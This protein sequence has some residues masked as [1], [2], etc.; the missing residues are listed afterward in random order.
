MKQGRTQR[1]ESGAALLEATLTMLT[2][3]L[4]LFGI[5]E[6]GR[7]INIQHTLTNA[8]RE[9]ARFA[10][11]PL[12]SSGTPPTPTDTLPSTG[13]VQARVQGYLDAAGLNGATATII[14]ER[15]CDPTDTTC[16]DTFTPPN[17]ATATAFHYSRVRVT[18][19]YKLLSTS[20]FGILQFTMQ[21]QATM[22]DE[23]NNK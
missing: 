22:R 14:L 20:F 5:F 16:T 7:I 8:A 1:S 13:A 2:L 23:T 11:L 21:G 4:L 10:A 19:P 6:A 17:C 12:Q 9:G 3:L 18:V 15:C